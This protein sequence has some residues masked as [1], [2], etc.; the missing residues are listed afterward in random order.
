M[1]VMTI[2]ITPTHRYFMRKSKDE[3]VRWIE[4]EKHGRQMLSFREIDEQKRVYS[5]DQLAS[6]CMKIVRT[7]PA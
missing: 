4:R 1:T 2:E 6:E 3:L 5:K 7:W